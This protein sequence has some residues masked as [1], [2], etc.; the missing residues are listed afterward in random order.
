MLPKRTTIYK[1]LIFALD[2][3]IIITFFFKN[4]QIFC[5]TNKCDIDS[6]TW[7]LLLKWMVTK[8]YVTQIKT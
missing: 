5:T 7:C 4:L 3:P 2:F 1:T 8:K 6:K